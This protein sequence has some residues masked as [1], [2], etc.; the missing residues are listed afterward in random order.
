[1]DEYVGLIKD[2]LDILPED[3]VIHRMTGDGAKKTL[4]A[5]LWSADKKKVLNRL[6]KEL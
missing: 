1:M 5:P 2:A 3:I 4:I 6:R